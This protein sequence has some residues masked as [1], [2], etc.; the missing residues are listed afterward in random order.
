MDL[1]GTGVDGESMDRIP[2]GIIGID[3]SERAQTNVG[4][5]MAI[6]EALLSNV[7]FS[8][9]VFLTR[10]MIQKVSHHHVQC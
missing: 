6:D 10:C 3:G 8:W 1:R 7:H 2:V 5:E 4:Q 9:G